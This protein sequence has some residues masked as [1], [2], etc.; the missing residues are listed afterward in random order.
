MFGVYV[1]LSGHI[2]PGGGFSGGAIMGAGLI[3]YLNADGFKRRVR[4][5]TNTK[6]KIGT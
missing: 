2:S 4:F 3:L 6:S 5:F 1:I